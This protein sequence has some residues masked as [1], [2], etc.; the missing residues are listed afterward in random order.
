LPFTADVILNLRKQEN[1]AT[2]QTKYVAKVEKLGT[3]KAQG[4]YINEPTY[5]KI[6]ELLIRKVEV[7]A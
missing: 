3:K 4:E 5:E 1:Q 2:G 7:K 6:R